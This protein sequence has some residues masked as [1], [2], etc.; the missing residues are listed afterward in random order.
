VSR[1]CGKNLLGVG[2]GRPFGTFG[3]FGK[4]TI[5]VYRN[6]MLFIA[7]LAAITFH[8][9]DVILAQTNYGSNRLS[10][11]LRLCRSHWDLL[12]P[13]WGPTGTHLAYTIAASP[14]PFRYAMVSSS[15]RFWV[16]LIDDGSSK[17]I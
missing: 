9:A 6:I 12:L 11:R 10:L 17:T 16:D 4:G 3:N 2:S 13:L 15:F 1:F 8:V 14:F 7:N 5:L